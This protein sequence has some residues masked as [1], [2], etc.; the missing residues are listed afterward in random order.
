[1][2]EVTDNDLDALRQQVSALESRNKD[3]EEK[4]K[5]SQRQ[6]ERAVVGDAAQRRFSWRSV[7]AAMFVLISIVLAPAAVMGAWARVQLVD[8]ERFVQTFAPLAESPAVQELIVDQVVLGIEESIDLDG[9]VTDVFSGLAALDLPDQARAALPLLEGPA[10]QGIRSMMRTGV[11]TLVESQ[12]FADLWAATLRET[13][14]Q[15]IA[16]IQ[17]D[18]DALVQLS[19]DGTL[20]VSLK[21]VIEGTKEY[22]ADQGIG[23]ADSIPVIDRSIPIVASDALVLVRV[24]YQ[25]STAVGYWLPWIALGALALGVLVARNRA[26]TLALAG[27][28]L[29]VA[30][31]TL[32]VGLKVGEAIFASAVSPSIMSAAAAHAIFGQLTMTTF[33]TLTA[34]IVL[35]LAL[36]IGAWMSGRSPWAV[37]LR[38][39]S[40][41]GFSAVRTAA[42]AKGLNPGRLGRVL[43]RWR[44]AIVVA[45]VAIGVAVL[46]MNRPI[47][48]AGVITTILV[49]LLVLIVIEVL[50]RP[51]EEGRLTEVPSPS[52]SSPSTPSTPSPVSDRLP[53]A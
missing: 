29:T 47:Q 1:M 8:T 27:A 10:V 22:L 42:D 52:M 32:V 19:S 49:V 53:E 18:P 15:V 35:S 2:A 50:R 44:R 9:L 21:K 30:F 14:S 25:L 13:H 45:V 4:V 17:G 39:A 26:R 23:F 12:Q 41:L 43:E 38:D 7:F 51:E 37:A 33:S 28:G 40:D 36:A 31:L 24:G 46:F 20:S 5:R 11:T 3:L 34:L 16:V 48:L 6:A